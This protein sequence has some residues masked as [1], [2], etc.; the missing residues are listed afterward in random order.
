MQTSKHQ[1]DNVMTLHLRKSRIWFAAGF[2]LIVMTAQGQSHCNCPNYLGGHYSTCPSMERNPVEGLTGTNSASSTSGS[3]HEKI[4]GD[5]QAQSAKAQ[6][7]HDARMAEQD[8]RHQELMNSVRGSSSPAGSS[9]ESYLEAGR[10]ERRDA[11]ALYLPAYGAYPPQAAPSNGAYPPQAAP[12]IAGQPDPGIQEREAALQRAREQEAR[13]REA[14][15]LWSGLSLDVGKVDRQAAMPWID[16]TSDGS[17]AT[18]NDPGFLIL[19]DGPA[20]PLPSGNEIAGFL[21][22]VRTGA[23]VMDREV[24]QPFADAVPRPI[25]DFSSFLLDEGANLALE[26]AVPALGGPLTVWGFLSPTEAADATIKWSPEQEEHL[27]NLRQKEES[28]ERA[29]AAGGSD[30]KERESRVAIP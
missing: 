27:R 6:A 23:N 12:Y 2:M 25:K 10:R 22:D 14:N 7:D 11:P 16:L 20:S 17:A 1:G 18:Q 28:S 4:M 3:S 19:D 13:Q 29:G 8:R 9:G 30:K 26:K 15:A 21:S 24:V 5:W